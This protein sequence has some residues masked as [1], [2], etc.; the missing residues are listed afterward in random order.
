MDFDT[1]NKAVHPVEAQWHF[2]T[3][4]NAGYTALT[5]EAVGFVRAYTYEHPVTGHKVRVNTGASCDYW[6]DLTTGKGGYWSDLAP[7]MAKLA[8]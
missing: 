7:H 2:E 8:S 3:M 4:A 6:T 5:K 1:A